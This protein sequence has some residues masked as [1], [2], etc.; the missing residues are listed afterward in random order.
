MSVHCFGMSEFWSILEEFPAPDLKVS[1][2]ILPEE[3]VEEFYR[4]QDDEIQS[5]Q[6]LTRKRKQTDTAN[7]EIP[8][9]KKEK[10][11]KSESA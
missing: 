7:T 9:K 4:F 8:L 2:P 10:G 3:D 1:K 5:T 11:Q 6:V